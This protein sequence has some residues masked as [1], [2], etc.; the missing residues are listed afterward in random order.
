MVSSSYDNGKFERVRIAKNAEVFGARDGEPG[1]AKLDTAAYDEAIKALDAVLAPQPGSR[2]RRRHQP[3][4]PRAAEPGPQAS[5]V[6]RALALRSFLSIALSISL[7]ACAASTGS[8]APSA[9]AARSTLVHSYSQDL[10]RAL[11]RRGVRPRALGGR[12]HVSALARRSTA[13][14]HVV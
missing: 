7:P 14:T 4:S 6:P 11:R 10:G 3:P 2:H 1:V 9:R 12:A 8:L 13:S 5:P